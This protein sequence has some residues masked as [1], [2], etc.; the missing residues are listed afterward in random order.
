L[1]A[2]LRPTLNSFAMAGLRITKLQNS[3][4]DE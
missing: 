3:T 2:K 4:K 1:V